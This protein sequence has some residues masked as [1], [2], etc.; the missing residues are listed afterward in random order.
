MVGRARAVKSRP[1][2]SRRGDGRRACAAR[3]QSVEIHP[4]FARNRY[5]DARVAIATCRGNERPLGT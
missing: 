5:E 4:L 3:L 1:R 2:R